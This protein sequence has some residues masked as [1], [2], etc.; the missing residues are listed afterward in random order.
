MRILPVV[1][2]VSILGL[3]A[4][5][6]SQGSGEA[7]PTPAAAVQPA[8]AVATPTAA[9]ETHVHDVACACSLGKACANVIKVGDEYLPLGGNVG[10]AP[11][12]FCGKKD[13]KAEVTGARAGDT[14]VA[15]SFALVEPAAKKN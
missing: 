9:A 8:G 10:V 1:F 13:L 6:A 12:S 11:M 4:C 2:A 15:T 7:T 14:F 3:A 5:D